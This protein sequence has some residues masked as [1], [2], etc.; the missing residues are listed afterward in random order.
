[1]F[2]VLLEICH[3]PFPEFG[4]LEDGDH[5]LKVLLITFGVIQDIAPVEAGKMSFLKFDGIYAG[6]GSH[7]D[8]FPGELGIPVMID[9]DL[10]DDIGR[11]CISDHPGP[12]SNSRTLFVACGVCRIH[13]VRI[14]FLP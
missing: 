7:I 1:L 4:F 3:F 8:E 11:K 14:L 10:G 9:S 5:V 2:S 6:I 13:F 12:D